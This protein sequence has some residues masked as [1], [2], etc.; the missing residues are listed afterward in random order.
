M[1]R[2][3][4]FVKSIPIPLFFIII[5]TIFVLIANFLSSKT[6][7]LA[8]NEK[9]N[10]SQKYGGFYLIGESN[11]NSNG[12]IY[13]ATMDFSNMNEDDLFKYNIADFIENNAYLIWYTLCIIICAILFYYIKLHN[14]IKN[15]NYASEKIAN[16]DLD[17]HISTDSKDELGKLCMSYEKM[18]E[19]LYNNNIKMWRMIE[20][21]KTVNSAL[22][23][24]IRTPLTILKG[25]TEILLKYIP[26]KKLSEDEIVEKL[27][28]MQNN[29]LR[30]EDF[31][32]DMNT[33]QQI[34]QLEP[35]YQEINIEKLI[36]EL[37]EN[38]NYLCMP[39]NINVLFYNEVKSQ[40]AALDSNMIHEVYNNII[41]NAIRYAKN[42]ITI[43]ITEL[44]RKIKFKI[45][46]DGEGF[47]KKALKEATH[48]YY[49]DTKEK[50]H[51][52]LGLYISKLLC[53][54]HNG[55]IKIL[56]NEGA[57]V[58]FSFSYKI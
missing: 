8:S 48:L 36:N 42:K 58:E 49:K 24:D 23:H 7:E 54:K 38:T 34:E 11:Y 29:I 6:V 21:K 50:S 13:E 2:L 30:L 28:I 51:F 26:D 5:V 12:V 57:V 32:H 43:N 46:D 16:N 15:L 17:F 20:D 31:L 27:E 25:N 45:Q 44:D 41:N 4:R 53:E 18:R 10:I 14:P 35:K 22:A 3:K 33:I 37:K 47:N 52:G 56:N 9:N 39:K 40:T 19:N 1:D 55:E